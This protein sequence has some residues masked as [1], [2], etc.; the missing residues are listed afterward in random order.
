M[1]SAAGWAAATPPERDRY[2][3]LLR[4][5]SLGVVVVGHWLMAVV[6]VEP[7]GVV[8]ATNLLALLLLTVAGP[9]PVSMVGLS[10]APVSNM[11]PPTL[12]LL[13][14]GAWLTGLALLVRAPVTRRLRRPRP[15]TAVVAANG[16]AMTVFLWHLTALFLATGAL[17]AAGLAGPAPGTGAWWALRPAWLLLLAAVTTALVA[18]FRRADAPADRRAAAGSTGP[19]GSAG[20]A[21]SARSARWVAA[22]GLAA[23]AVGVF[24]ISRTGFAGPLAGRPAALLGLPLT[25]LGAA[26]L[27][28]A[29]ALLPA[30]VRRLPKINY[31]K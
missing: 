4:V 12:A 27:I 14:H 20:A 30:A 25:P 13:A 1:R 9:Y 17:L 29:G 23:A 3:D 26:A 6:T 15:W 7:G 10:G 24:G 19:V 11:S 2:V 16:V 22:A 8:R 31:R 18:A 5:V 21:G 28:A